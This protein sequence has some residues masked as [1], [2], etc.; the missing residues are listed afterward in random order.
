MRSM[1]QRTTACMPQAPAWTTTGTSR[2]RVCRA[3][4]RRGEDEGAW[5]AAHSLGQSSSSSSWVGGSQQLCPGQEQHALCTTTLQGSATDL[6]VRRL[7]SN[8]PFCLAAH[9]AQASRRARALTVLIAALVGVAVPTGTGSSSR[10]ARS[11]PS[12]LPR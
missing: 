7:P 1:A 4:Y 11:A 6:C 3:R 5:R 8:A 9:Q 10:T 2:R 12:T